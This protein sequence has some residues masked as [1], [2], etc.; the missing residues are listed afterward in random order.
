MGLFDN[1]LSGIGSAASS[2][3]T[4]GAV[5]A[6]GLLGSMF[7][8]SPE[9]KNVNFQSVDAGRYGFQGVYQKFLQSENTRMKDDEQRRIMKMASELVPGTA[10][11]R[12]GLASQG[13]GGATS[14]VMANQQRNTAM[15]KA[16]DTGMQSA[17]IG[18]GNL[19]K[20]FLG[21]TG[22]NEGMYNQASQF[23]AQ[24][25]FNADL[26]NSKGQFEA[27][28]GQSQ[29]WQNMFGQVA[30]AG[31]GMMGQEFGMNKFKEMFGKKDPFN[32]QPISQTQTL[33]GGNAYTFPEDVS[34][35]DINGMGDVTTPTR[36]GNSWLFPPEI[37]YAERP[38]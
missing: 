6:A 30:T 9:W 13:L 37:N 15:G 24:G 36:F 33:G 1:I 4:G 7:T 19:D 27:D 29:K 21:L 32:I 8:D 38:R 23:N 34:Y 16:L 5:G 26:A 18:F 2:L 31:F 28:S 3:G 35:G 14:N 11:F 20:Q 25:Q 17:E 10:S 22:E 12:G